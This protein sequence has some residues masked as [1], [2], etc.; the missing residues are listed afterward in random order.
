MSKT[1]ITNET[2]ANAYFDPSILQNSSLISQAYEFVK[3]NVTEFSG[4][5]DI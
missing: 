4:A 5:L 1:V 2:E 3:D